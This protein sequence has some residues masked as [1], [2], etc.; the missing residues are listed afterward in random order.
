ME[1]WGREYVV[2]A[3]EKV[4]TKWVRSSSE[5]APNQPAATENSSVLRIGVSEQRPAS[6]WTP[7][8]VGMIFAELG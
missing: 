1:G 8:A 3:A 7:P 6:C 4:E 5:Y 2:V